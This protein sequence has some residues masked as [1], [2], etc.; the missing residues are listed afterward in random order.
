LELDEQMC[1][2]VFYG[3]DF[4]PDNVK[5]Y[6]C[7]D[8]PFTKIRK[9]KEN[10]ELFDRYQ[11]DKIHDYMVKGYWSKLDQIARNHSKKME[12][13]FVWLP[14]AEYQYDEF[15]KMLKRIIMYVPPWTRIC[16]FHR[17]FPLASSAPMRLGYESDYLKTNLQQICM[18]NLD[19]KSRDIRARELRNSEWNFSGCKVFYHQ[20]QASKGT[21]IFI[22]VEYLDPSDETFKIVGMIRLRMNGE[23]KSGILPL[24]KRYK[25]SLLIREL[26][27]YGNL[28]SDSKKKHG[29]HSGVGRFLL[30]CAEHVAHH[31]HLNH[32][33]VISGIGVRN[34]YQK[35]GYSR[36]DD[37]Y[38]IKPVHH[39]FIP[40]IF[41]NKSY[42]IIFTFNN[43]KSTGKVEFHVYHNY[44]WFFFSS[45][46][47][48]YIM[49]YT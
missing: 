29:Q 21:E 33:I 7:V 32:I 46:V 1:R 34:Y 11:V 8:V 41:I 49:L 15:L 20:Y 12:D 26:H 18:E 40:I 43:K 31:F 3:D 35:M 23:C 38:M 37:N 4:Q 9:Y 28:Q 36:T 10:A 42:F 14:S 25:K 16:R 17:D 13:I 48:L 2:E 30:N 47:L 45:I 39:K 27:V 5:I 24:F 44:F 19:T 22:S 6:I